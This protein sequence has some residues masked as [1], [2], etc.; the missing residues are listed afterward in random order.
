MDLR[1]FKPGEFI[2]NDDGSISTQRSHT[3]Q[4]ENG[5]WVNIPSLWTD[6]DGAVYNLNE[7]AIATVAKKYEDKNGRKF[8][9]FDDLDQAINAA[10]TKSH[11]FGAYSEENKPKGLLSMLQQ[12]PMLGQGLLAAGLDPLLSGYSKE[13]Y[14]PGAYGILSLPLKQGK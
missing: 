1:P 12:G 5:K 13:L 11:N 14:N 6:K 7:D 2:R 3:L 8:S 4:D 9:R 10:Q